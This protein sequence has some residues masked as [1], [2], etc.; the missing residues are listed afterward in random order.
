MQ[1]KKKSRPAEARVMTWA[2]KEASTEIRP[3]IPPTKYPMAPATFCIVTV[4]V[5][6]CPLCFKSG[7]VF[8][9]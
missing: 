9:T 8:M 6:F 7:V 3:S 1:M 5:R 4:M 2:M